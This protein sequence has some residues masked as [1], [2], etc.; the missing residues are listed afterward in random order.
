MKD[1][2]LQVIKTAPEKTLTIAD[3]EDRREE[4]NGKEH[5]SVGAEW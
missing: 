3:K 2:I 4:S 1:L 5:K